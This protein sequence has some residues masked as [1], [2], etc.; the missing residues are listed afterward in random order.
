[1][2]TSVVGIGKA[3]GAVR[4]LHEVSLELV[5]GRVHALLGE[6]GAGKSSLSK[7][8]SGV[9]RPDTGRL[10]LDGRP[11]AFANPDDARRAGVRTVF[12]ELSMIP[13][14]TVAENL[15][16]ERPPRTRMGHLSRSRSAQT[17]REQ[18]RR[19]EADA[20]ID[21]TPQTRVRDLTLVERQVLE[22]VKALSLPPGLL[23]FDEATSALPAAESS[24]ALDRARES[25]AAGAAVLFVSHR[26]HEVR[27]LADE[28]TVMRNGQ[29]VTGGP[30]ASFTEDQLVTEMLGRRVER[31]YPARTSG[32]TGDV[33]LRVEGASAEPLE[34]EAGQ[35]YGVSGLE[36][37]GQAAFMRAVAAVSP[38]DLTLT[39]HG[40]PFRPRTPAAAIARGVAFVPEDRQAE[41]L[42]A[43]QSIGSNI[44]VSALRQFAGWLGLNRRRETA[45]ITK[46]AARLKV[47]LDR[48]ALPVSSLS[49]G[50]QQKVILSRVLLTDPRLLLL[51]D[52]TRG[53]DVGTKAEIFDL[54]AQQAA[55][56]V[57]VVL[58]S[59]DM[60]E[61]VG[62]CHRVAVF[63]E[64]SVVA[65]LDQDELSEDSILR[66]ALRGH[67]S[68]RASVHPN[69]KE[70]V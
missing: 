62:L 46:Q 53:V 21:V 5:P 15:A 19:F 7:V 1:M 40:E 16:F 26:M 9:I 24:W 69:E 29:V 44:S 58:Y 12:Q 41:G 42:F 32:G 65:V 4:A 38:T 36:G 68:L 31:L 8:L 61:V 60:S 57:A 47:P 11:I 56:G 25:A 39:L 33:V 35:I 54:V 22:I 14:L 30:A 28:I 45:A 59:S 51:Y 27:E 66:A 20:L 50:N 17:V 2:H 18:L 55:A 63:S 13:D 70:A 3:Y 43:D 52:C 23:I 34:F 48:L 67:P 10:E 6:N 64:G 49:G 37:Q